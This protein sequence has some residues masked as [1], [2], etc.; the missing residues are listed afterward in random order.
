MNHNKFAIG[1]MA[2]AL[3]WA[4]TLHAAVTNEE[5]AK[6]GTTLTATGAEKAG[7][8]E[9]T[10]PEYTGGLTKAPAAY[11]KGDG[12]RPDPFADEKPLFTVDAKNAGQYADKLTEGA[13][14]LLKKYP[15]Y[16]M[17]VY[18]AHRTVAFPKYVQDN[19]RKCALAAKTTHGG[20]SLEGCHAG[21][22]FP[23]PKTGFEVMWN[24]TTRFNSVNNTEEY[25]GAY[26]DAAGK[27]ILSTQ[28]IANNN[29]PYWDPQ[30]AGSD[31][32]YRAK[33][34]YTG[35]ARRSGEIMMLND[36]LNYGEAGRR[37]WIYLPGQR[38]VRLAPSLAFDTPNASTG[39]A[40][41]YDDIYIFLGSMER[42]DF[43]LVGKKEMLVPY[44]DYKMAYGSKAVDLFKP[45]HLNP[46][47]VRWELH[48]VWVVEA[49]LAEGKRHLYSKRIF[50]V[51]EDSWAALASDQYDGQGKLYRAGFA[52]MTP[53]Y[54]VPAPTADLHGHYDLISGV[55][56]LNMYTAETGGFRFNDGLPESA[57]SADGLA[58][59]GVR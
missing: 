28:G 35:P 58:G 4:G 33:A 1:A 43:K 10:I 7:N 46:D 27:Y 21:V 41:T 32:F 34:S 47:Y 5:A 22:P 18:P 26:V 2:L 39:G 30:K 38:R 6:L 31:V 45:N 36:P 23:I 19:T 53:S 25:K 59:G 8:K 49:T 29:Y 40:S 13:K 52:Y 14:A 16:R 20:R 56:T 57:W 15:S 11:K 9:G 3:G 48:R 54:E 42:F 44:N 51:D 37:A 24:H 12:I 17:D 50:Y 55:Y